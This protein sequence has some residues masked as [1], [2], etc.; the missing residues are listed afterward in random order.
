MTGGLWDPLGGL[1]ETGLGV[2]GGS[3]LV[4]PVSVVGTITVHSVYCRK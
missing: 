1:T 2:T 3:E 4:A